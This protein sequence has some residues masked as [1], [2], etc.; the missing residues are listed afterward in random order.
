MEFKR[1]DKVTTDYIEGEEDKVRI[2]V[3]VKPSKLSITGFIVE[4]QPRKGIPAYGISSW[5]F[6]KYNN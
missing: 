6:R 1:G 4:V 5:W 3:N 2:V